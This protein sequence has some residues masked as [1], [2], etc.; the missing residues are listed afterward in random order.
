MKGLFVFVVLAVVAVGVTMY[1]RASREEQ[2]EA[3]SLKSLPP[4][5][6][7]VVG[8]MGANEQA[9]FFNEYERKKRKLSVS[10]LLWIFFGLYYVYNRKVGLQIGYWLSWFIGVG[11]VWWVIDLFRMPSIVRASNEQVARDALQTLSLGS[12]FSS[13]AAGQGFAQRKPTPLEDPP[14]IGNDDGLMA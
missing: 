4:S 12:M 8:K 6:Q 11:V 14:V 3:R 5:V 10:Y 2:A 9:A 7:N 13:A 1:V